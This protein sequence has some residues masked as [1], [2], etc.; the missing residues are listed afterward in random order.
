M[1]DILADDEQAATAAATA[2]A[3][4]A[5]YG[6]SSASTLQQPADL[7]GSLLPADNLF[8][9]LATSNA[10]PG[11]NNDFGQQLPASLP[12]DI[13]ACNAPL[14]TPQAALPLP[15]PQILSPR[16][17]AHALGD[18]YVSAPTSAAA[19]AADNM[20][21]T[22]AFAP[23][24]A[25]RVADS[26]AA[27]DTQ[28]AGS[29]ASAMPTDPMA[30]PQFW[31]TS[32][33]A[34]SIYAAAML[35]CSQMATETST[36]SSSHLAAGAG[37]A[38]A[39][40]ANTNMN[41]SRT[42][43]ASA[44][45]APSAAAAHKN[46]ALRPPKPA[47]A[48]AAVLDGLAEDAFLSPTA[49]LYPGSGEEFARHCDMVS[50]GSQHPRLTPPTTVPSQ[51]HQSVPLSNLASDASKPYAAATVPSLSPN[52]QRPVAQSAG[53]LAPQQEERQ[54]LLAVL[55]G[56]MLQ[57]EALNAL[58][59]VVRRMLDSA[60]LSPVDAIVLVAHASLL[61]KPGARLQ[62]N[63]TV[64]LLWTRQILT[65]LQVS[66]HVCDAAMA[67]CNRLNLVRS[68]NMGALVA[69]N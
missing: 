51:K 8:P 27:A 38:A 1:A 17:F 65:E 22:Q 5:F 55:S 18:Y 62:K 14:S 46:S 53:G 26:A 12:T 31:Q 35:A 61:D 2:A 29:M 59:H 23:V 33:A 50:G 52:D 6:T 13:K 66:S 69:S 42:T 41:K 37:A 57:D 7:F 39:I 47:A 63:E 40:A 19:D 3:M 28:A 11:N 9:L 64:L 68:F 56:S 16:S 48:P 32:P 44:A 10:Y 24:A 36:S 49:S 60:N 30:N 4:A 54:N 21:G 15:S 67:L 25:S 20:H 43:T 34:S 58:M 45:V